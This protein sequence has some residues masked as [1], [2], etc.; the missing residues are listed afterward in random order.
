VNQV[1][2]TAEQKN[3]HFREGYH[4]MLDLHSGGQVVRVAPSA[5]IQCV[6]SPVD[7]SRRRRTCASASVSTPHIGGVRFASRR[8]AHARAVD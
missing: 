1:L 4:V 8:S 2:L 5:S 3:Q 6:A 7:R